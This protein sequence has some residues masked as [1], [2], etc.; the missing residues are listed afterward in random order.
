MGRAFT[1]WAFRVAVGAA[2]PSQA[3]LAKATRDPLPAPGATRPRITTVRG[4]GLDGSVQRR[5]GNVKVA[6]SPDAVA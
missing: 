6:P 2:R 1:A 4:T 3:A 5:R